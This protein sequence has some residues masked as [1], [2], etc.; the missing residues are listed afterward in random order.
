MFRPLAVAPRIAVALAGIV[1][2]VIPYNLAYGVPI[3]GAALIITA[4]I[5]WMQWRR[6]Q[7]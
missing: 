1:I 6:A 3:L 2:L 4:A 7:Q 5:A